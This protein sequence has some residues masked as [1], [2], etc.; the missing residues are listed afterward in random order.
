M[1]HHLSKVGFIS[2]CG[3]CGPEVDALLRPRK[4]YRTDPGP[5][6]RT[7]AIILGQDVGVIGLPLM[8]PSGGAIAVDV[9]VVGPGNSPATIRLIS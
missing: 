7:C 1:D 4:L 8:D 6:G 2:D 9:R 3:D 5:N